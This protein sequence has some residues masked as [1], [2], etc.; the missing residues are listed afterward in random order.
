ML[1]D[2]SNALTAAPALLGWLLL[3][4][5]PE[6]VSAGYIVETECYL[7]SDAASHSYRGKTPR[8]EIM[9]G[10][11]GHLY[12]Y[13]TYGLHHCL[14]IVTGPDGSGE[15]VLI[16]ALQPVEGLDLMRSRRGPVTDRQLASGPAKL[17]QA[18]GV[19][20]QLLPGFIPPA[21]TQSTRIGISHGTDKAWRFY[22]TNNAFVSKR[23]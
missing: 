6:G 23:R 19:N 16:R 3:H 13:F 17:T 18:M 10:P 7:A 8:T 11:A 4:A 5:S 20:R 14:N 9:F 21:V 12:V 2:L 22:I 1:P 15:A